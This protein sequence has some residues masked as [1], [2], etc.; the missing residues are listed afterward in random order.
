M[1]K[2]IFRLNAFIALGYTIFF[3]LLSIL[4]SNIGRGILLGLIYPI[5]A[6]IHFV[7]MGILMTINH[8]QLSIDKRNGYMASFFFIWVLLIL[9]KI[10]EFYLI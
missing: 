3:V 2:K 10:S 6:G 7:I 4:L 8:F 5:V 9:V 1:I